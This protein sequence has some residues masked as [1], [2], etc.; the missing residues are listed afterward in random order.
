MAETELDELGLRA[1]KSLVFE[2]FNIVVMSF[3]CSVHRDPRLKAFIES[4][5]DSRG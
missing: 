3:A 1:T 2:I 4:G 5:V